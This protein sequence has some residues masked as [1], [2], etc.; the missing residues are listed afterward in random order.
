MVGIFLITGDMPLN[1]IDKC[2]IGITGG[3]LTSPIGTA[4]IGRAV[5]CARHITISVF[6]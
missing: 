5:R 3:A 6:L 2:S 1:G 4:N